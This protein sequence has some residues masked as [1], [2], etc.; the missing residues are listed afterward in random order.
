MALR[1][2]IDFVS[3]DWFEGW[4]WD[5]ARPDLRVSL[6]VLADGAIIGRC[7]ADRFRPD[8]LNAKIGDGKH[9]FGLRL[10]RRLSNRER[11]LIEIRREED[12]AA[13]PGSPKLVETSSSFD[14]DLADD[15]AR[16]LAAAETEEDFDRR[17]AF[18]LDQT[19]KLRNAYSKKQTGAVE[20]EKRRQLKWQDPAAVLAAAAARTAAD[21]PLALVIDDR[22]PDIA[23]D[24]GS[25]A[26]VSHIESLKRLGFDVSFT[27]P[28]MSGDPGALEALGVKAYLKPWVNSVEEVLERQSGAYRLVYLHR[29]SN[30]SLYLWLVRKHQPRARVVYGLA[31]LHHLRFAREAAVEKRDDLRLHSEWVKRQEL[32]T[33]AQ[34]DAVV[35]H[36]TVEQEILR[37]HLPFKKIIVAPWHVA[38]RPSAASF[39]D[40]AGVGFVAH[41][42][43]RPN[44]DAVHFL[45]GSIMPEV[46]AI[47]PSIACSIAGTGMPD[48][49]RQLAGDR[50]C[51]V[52][53]VEDLN[54]FFDKVRLTVAPLAFG[55]G[56]KGKVLDSLAAGAPCVCTP[57][58]AE[59]LGLPAALAKFVR[60]SPAELAQAIV[61]L[62]NDESLN[63]EAA[64]AG[65]GF[66]SA[67]ASTARVDAALAEAAG[68]A[69][70]VTSEHEDAGC[71]PEAH[72][73]VSVEA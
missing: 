61:A 46:W 11:H 33:A 67:F 65:S 15:F 20:L 60:E 58:A 71:G 25:K 35:T 69:A 26:I 44:I 17:L 57:I 5:D 53:A 50:I 18:L 49:L 36:S 13:L 43:H 70:K 8:L 48:K 32:W 16:V 72:N 39:S 40:R 3:N 23:R 38:P 56:I 28:D 34:A 29:L 7:L 12:G 2:S 42:G 27:A 62:H 14:M 51:V 64:A 45:V 6:V 19:E 9:A 63:R 4:A 54:G 24:A 68:I 1:G 59:G 22:L 47:D 41:F 21:R 37:R 55:A 66:I 31:D 10:P 52:G 30:A 73:A